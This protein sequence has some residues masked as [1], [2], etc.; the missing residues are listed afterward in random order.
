MTDGP[1]CPKIADFEPPKTGPRQ[2]PK[3]NH[4]KA[5]YS[6]VYTMLC[7]KLPCKDFVVC[8]SKVAK[9]LYGSGKNI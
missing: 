4:W 2:R 5:T 8:T 1:I 3:F 6:P 7:E 9:D